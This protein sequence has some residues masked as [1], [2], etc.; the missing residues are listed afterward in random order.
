[1]THA[2]NVLLIE[3]ALVSLILIVFSG[4]LRGQPNYS[5]SPTPQHTAHVV[6]HEAAQKIHQAQTHYFVI[7]AN[8]S[9][10]LLADLF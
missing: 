10:R 6:E 8:D 4:S 1:M 3:T 7:T 5:R 2:R 9:I